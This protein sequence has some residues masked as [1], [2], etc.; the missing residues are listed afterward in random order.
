MQEIMSS[1]SNALPSL[2]A[3]RFA[4]LV[5]DALTKLYDPAAL[6]TNPLAAVLG[7]DDSEAESRAVALRR[8]LRDSIERLRPEERVPYGEPEWLPYRLLWMRYVH[9]RGLL[10]VC[11]E[12]GLARSTFYRQHQQALDALTSLLWQ[13]SQSTAHSVAQATIDTPAPTPDIEATSRALH[14][15]QESRREAVNLHDLLASVV[16]T[17]APLAAQGFRVQSDAPAALPPVHANLA[18]LRQAILALLTTLEQVAGNMDVWLIGELGGVI[19][20]G[21]KPT[22]SRPALAALTSTSAYAFASGAIANYGGRIA[23]GDSPGGLLLWIS[24]PLAPRQT[25]LLV[26]D[27]QD[28]IRLYRRWLE[29]H[30]YSVSVARTDAQLE[31]A[32]AAG[33]PDAI[34]LDLLMPQ[35]DGWQVLQRLKADPATRMIPV[36][37]SSV[38]AESHL[39]RALGAAGTLRK[40][41]SE[42]DLMRVLQAVMSQVDN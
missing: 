22:G 42:S 3:I 34:L 28:T 26:D 17:I 9:R 1:K 5:K 37:I 10:D 2:D 16:Q 29:A 35:W 11:Q 23:T 31:Q 6:Q 14:L 25:V 13:T 12:L 32:L 33:R 40:P 7:M 15:V 30:R 27:D 38:L 4:Y 21:A 8:L 18:V 24:M 36:V 39:V 20:W 19:L 41:V